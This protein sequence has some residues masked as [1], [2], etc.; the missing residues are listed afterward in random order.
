[1]KVEGFYLKVERK[2]MKVEGFYL[3][4][5]R[6]NIIIYIKYIIQNLIISAFIAYDVCRK[7]LHVSP[8][9]LFFKHF[10]SKP[11]YELY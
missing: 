4:V 7:R 1:M 5:E 10:I 11:Q 8:L 9:L 3:K 6:Y 2:T